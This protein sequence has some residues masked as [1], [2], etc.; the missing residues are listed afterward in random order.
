[1]IGERTAENIKITIGT[2]FPDSRHEEMDIRGRDMVTGLPR[3][4][5]IRSAEIEKALHESVS[6]DCTSS[7]KCIR[8]NTA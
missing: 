6:S 3:T 7:E 2:V 8:K 5:T 4:I 1:M